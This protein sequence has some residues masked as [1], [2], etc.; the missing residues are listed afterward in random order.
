MWLTTIDFD[1]FEFY[2]KC[3]SGTLAQHIFRSGSH[4]SNFRTSTFPRLDNDSPAVMI[5]YIIL[6]AG[7]EYRKR[8]RRQRVLTDQIHLTMQDGPRNRLGFAIDAEV[9]DCAHNILRPRCPTGPSASHSHIWSHD[10]LSI[11]CKSSRTSFHQVCRES[12][13]DSRKFFSTIT[14]CLNRGG[15]TYLVVQASTLVELQQHLLPD[16][17]IHQLLDMQHPPGFQS[18][19]TGIVNVPHL[20]QHIRVACPLVSLPPIAHTVAGRGRCISQVYHF[21]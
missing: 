4:I 12:L 8:V 15:V 10:N 18:R 19:N 21:R 20:P 11:L 7:A 5:H 9:Y 2:R 13:G 1:G 6:G 3:W 14:H 17:A 16:S